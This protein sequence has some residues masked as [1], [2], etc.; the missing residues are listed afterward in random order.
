[1]IKISKKL[2][3]RTVLVA[4]FAFSGCVVLWESPDDT[5]KRRA[6]L[7]EEM[8]EESVANMADPLKETDT[9]V[10]FQIPK[11][12]SS[13]IEAYYGCM[14]LTLATRTGIDDGHDQDE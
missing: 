3:R 5:I 13:P 6:S 1:M 8:Y 10:Y 7:F 12:G 2:A 9:P 11:S 4:T 14:G